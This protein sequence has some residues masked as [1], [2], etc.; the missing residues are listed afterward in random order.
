MSCK[1]GILPHRGNH[2]LGLAGSTPFVG[3]HDTGQLPTLASG[4]QYPPAAPI[5]SLTEDFM[6]F[7][8]VATAAVAFLI[9]GSACASPKTI[10][11]NG[12]CDALTHIHWEKTHRGPGSTVMH[13]IWDR[14]ACNATST[15]AAGLKARNRSDDDVTYTPDT[16]S[17]GV[18][19]VVVRL[20]RSRTWISW[21]AHGRLLDSG[22]WSKRSDKIAPGSAV[23]APSLLQT[24][25]KDAGAED[26]GTTPPPGWLPPNLSFDGHCDGLT[27]IVRK[28]S[29]AVWVL[30]GKWDLSQCGL[31]STT[32]TALRNRNRFIN[33]QGVGTY[34][35]LKQGLGY[36]SVVLEV[37]ID[38]DHWMYLD[39]KGQLLA[40]GHWTAGL[41][42]AGGTVSMP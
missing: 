39:M 30:E 23:G 25:A 37:D 21:D 2:V 18:S 13:A 27:D 1:A 26:A 34:D 28:F 24:A 29:H 35:T 16:T 6:K 42:H 32:F 11:F 19:P 41:P 9:A 12:R 20:Y 33:M 15:R 5:T 38:N 3:L 31:A 22:S 40:E 8:Q 4:R 14:S 17:L 36:P 7:H 10:Q